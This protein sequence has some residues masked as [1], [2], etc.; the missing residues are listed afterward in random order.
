MSDN[1]QIR[2]ATPADEKDILDIFHAV[3]ATG[4]THALGPDT[5]DEQAREFCLGKNM[6][7]YV[8]LVDGKTEATYLIKANQPD[9]GSH[10]A[11]AGFMVHPRCKTKG[12]GTRMCE[13]ALQEA[14]AMGFQAMQ[15]NYVVSTNERAVSLWKRMGFSIVGTVPKAFKHQTLGLV[16]IHIMHRFI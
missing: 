11:N 6:R 5:T 7:T 12:L 2:R 16:D 13:H 10:V 15:F 4:D 9:L 14:K 3:V 8:A 1:E